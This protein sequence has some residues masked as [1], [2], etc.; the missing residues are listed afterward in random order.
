MSTTYATPDTIA[1]ACGLLETPGAY[2]LA[3][4]VAFTMALTK[5]QIDPASIV[6]L[7]KIDGL[8]GVTAEPAGGFS[9][10]ALSTHGQLLR[11][12]RIAEHEPQLREMFADVGNVRVRAVGTLGGNL[13]YADPR[14]DPA[15]LLGALGAEVVIESSTGKRTVPVADFAT[16]SFSTVL[17]PGELLCSVNV[18]PRP[19]GTRIGWCK[20]QTNSLDDY[21][22][23]SLAVGF[24]ESNG[25]ITRPR[26]LVGAADTHVH[27]QRAAGLL[28]GA[29]IDADGRVAPELIE[30]VADA[31]AADIKPCSNHRGS[32]MYKRDLVRVALNRAMMRTAKAPRGESCSL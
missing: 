7:A 11:D 22:T 1:E 2:A 27:T 20:L 15:P 31:L 14:H 8:R 6:S 12:E 3:G 32:A 30:E 4:G 17:Q 21:A 16:D 13:A 29:D 26:I 5:G 19:A 28:E 24:E 18:P 10:G 9:I 23:L 25:R